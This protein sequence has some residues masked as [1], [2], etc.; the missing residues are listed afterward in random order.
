MAPVLSTGSTP[1]TSACATGTVQLAAIT[2][3]G[4]SSCKVYIYVGADSPVDG[5]IEVEYV[6]KYTARR[7]SVTGLHVFSTVSTSGGVWSVTVAT[8]ET[9]YVKGASFIQTPTFNIRYNA[10]GI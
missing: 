8:C 5:R 1:R 4:L 3:Q 9:I 2:E 10:L 6:F 7:P